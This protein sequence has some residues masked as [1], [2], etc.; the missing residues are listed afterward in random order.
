MGAITQAIRPNATIGSI[1]GGALIGG[2]AG[3]VGAG[4]GNIVAGGTFFGSQVAST[5]GFWAGA[6]SGAA[7]GFT[8]GFVGS[9]GNAWLNGASFGD[10]LVTGLKGGA[11]SGISGGLTN[12]VISG[13]RA[14]NH[15]GSFFSG[16]G[17][18]F[19]YIAPISSSSDEQV[20]VGKEME[21]SNEYARGF[22]DRNFGEIKGLNKLIADG[23]VPD[24][25]YLIKGDRIYKC[26]YEVKGSTKLV[27]INKWDVYLYKVAFT[28]KQQLY[29]TM[30]HEYMHIAH[31][32]AG[33]TRAPFRAHYGIKRWEYLQAKQWN[34]EPMRFYNEWMEYYKYFDPSFHH[35]NFGFGIIKYLPKL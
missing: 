1:L 13:I 24:N 4:V 20:V 34:F 10:G 8:G 18:T 19:D 26:G 33:I 12:G 27:G 2:L 15:G 3:M 22:S 35:E 32:L 6:A 25:S 9:A 29:L 30:G 21:Y 7:G 5:V 14:S 11:I 31:G 16:E 28:S 17:A 23:S